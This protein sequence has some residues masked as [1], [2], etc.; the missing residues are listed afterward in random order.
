VSGYRTPNVSPTGPLGGRYRIGTAISAGAMG[1]VYRAID[2]DTGDE[3]AVKRLLDVSNRARFE[4]EARLLSALDHPGIVA[5][6]DYVVSDGGDYLIMDLVRGLDLTEVLR[7]RGHPGLPE[8]DAVGYGLRVAET[9]GYLHGQG[10]IHR[11]LK[12]ANLILSGE[13]VVLVDFGVARALS[14]GAA[15][16]APTTVGFG[17]P[18]VLA[19]G[20][21]SPASDVYGLAATLWALLAGTPPRAGGTDALE[22]VSAPVTRALRAALELDPARRPA[23]AREFAD[24]LERPL[25]PA[26]GR[27][28]ARSVTTAGRPAAL[29]ESVLHAAAATFEAPA[30]SLALKEADGTLAYVAAWGASAEE[31]VGI[32]LAPGEGLAGAVATDGVGLAIAECR[33]DP[34]FAAAVAAGTGYV[35][36]TMLLAPVRREDTTI[37][38]L[39]LLDRRSGEP[40]TATDLPNAQLFAD[41][42]ATAL[43]Q[44]E[45]PAAS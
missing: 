43:T 23:A 2:T 35:P 44:A 13:D 32:R 33:A 10:V 31:V 4:A 27:P 1:A 26:R 9:L 37:G 30:V 7:I 28:L 24:L 17:A 29:I 6:R 11:D 45:S 14:V 20:V 25:P 39:S 8:A 12:P 36:H 42:V 38:V 3:V 5:V 40:F 34:R 41:L 16:A 22:G 18:E 19:G 21:V 15:T